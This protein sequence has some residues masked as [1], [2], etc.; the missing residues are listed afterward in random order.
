MV[1]LRCN[2]SDYTA[3]T[4]I[5]WLV[6]RYLQRQGVAPCS[7]RMEPKLKFERLITPDSRVSVL[8]LK[9]LWQWAA[10]LLPGDQPLGIKVAEMLVPSAAE[11][12]PMPF[13]LLEGVGR[14][15]PTLQEGLERQV[16]FMRLLCEGLSVKI[17]DWT[18][19]RLL[20]SWEHVFPQLVPHDLNDFHLAAT[21]MLFR[22]VLGERAIVP[23]ET[24]ITRSEPKYAPAYRAFFGPTL[25]FRASS[26]ALVV[27]TAAMRGLLPSYDPVMLWSMEHH[28]R[29]L[30]D[31]LPRLPD[32]LL[33]VREHIEAELPNGKPTPGRIAE[34]FQLSSRSFYRR[35][36]SQAT[37]FQ[38]QLDRVRY[39][40]AMK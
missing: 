19:G 9:R 30:L 34:R 14:F 12:W 3:S 20:I 40:L 35:L 6:L 5:C 37:T 8:E 23:V 10:T 25:R 36:H 18:R 29:T 39:K 11:S 1:V 4:G 26:P 7:V 2:V 38:Q 13:A 33:A 17:E 22:R 28:A 32:F 16:P 15:S 27:S 31:R 24:W 21:L